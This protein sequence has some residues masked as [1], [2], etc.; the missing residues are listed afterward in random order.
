MAQL[1]LGDPSQEIWGD[2]V[3]PGGLA[4]PLDEMPGGSELFSLAVHGLVSL[5]VAGRCGP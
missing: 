1:L 4:A 5:G 2:A 3:Y